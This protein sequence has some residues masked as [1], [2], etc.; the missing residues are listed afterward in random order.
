MSLRYCSGD[1]HHVSITSRC[2]LLTPIPS[3]VMAA[4][5]Y[6]LQTQQH[7]TTLET[8]PVIDPSDRIEDQET[9]AYYS[10]EV[11][12]SASIWAERSTRFSPEWR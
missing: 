2:K 5:H 9:I 7:Y 1:I 8:L 11:S 3:K 6:I 10:R 12:K 4:P